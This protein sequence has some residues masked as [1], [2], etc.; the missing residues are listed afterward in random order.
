MVNFKENAAT[1]LLNKN[2]IS[3]KQFK[4]ISM[5]RSLKIVSLYNEL[6]FLLYLSVLLF[7]SGVGILIYKNIDTI[8]HTII[9][10]LLFLLIL[11]CFY[12]SIKNSSGFKK[13]ETSFKNPV[14]DYL[15]L[16]GT[17]LSATFVGYLQFQYQL[18]GTSFGLSALITAV[19]AFIVAHYFDNKSALSIGLSALTASVGIAITPQSLL[20]NEVYSN[21]SLTFYGLFLG[22]LI[23]L[24]TEYAIKI[25]LKKHFRI[26]YFTFALHLLG[27]CCIS[28]LLIKFNQLESNWWLLFVPVFVAFVFYFNKISY[29][30]QSVSLF[31]FTLIYAYIGFTIFLGILC[32]FVDNWG[33]IWV[34]FLFFIPGYFGF[35]IVLFIKAIKNF[36]TF[37]HDRI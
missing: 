19:I 29:R 17:I 18:F 26:V 6:R 22:V 31:L 15:V 11:V 5:Y 32:S 25:N 8:G 14:F 36:N 12:Y 30:L 37:K 34:L 4:Q 16:L 13:I 35:S 21:S 9:L 3:D 28:G 7:T 1:D 33:D 24:W 23:V 2:L 20:K 10:V 27:V